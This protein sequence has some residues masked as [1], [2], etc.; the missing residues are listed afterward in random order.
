[1]F[2]RIIGAGLA[3]CE[4]AWQAA[5]RGLDVELCEM[6]PQ[7]RGP[8]H[9]TDRLAELVMFLLD[10]A[11]PYAEDL[12]PERGQFVDAPSLANRAVLR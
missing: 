5:E 4:A 3:G 11:H 2:L 12:F 1:M 9:K 7:Q 6:R 10:N 8:A